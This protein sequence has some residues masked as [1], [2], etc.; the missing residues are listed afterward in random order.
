MDSTSFLF[1]FD[2]SEL[3]FR[4]IFWISARK[5]EFL[6]FLKTKIFSHPCSQNYSIYTAWAEKP[7]ENQNASHLIR[8]ILYFLR[9]FFTGSRPDF[10]ISKNIC[11]IFWMNRQKI[12][13]RNKITVVFVYKWT[14]SI[15]QNKPPIREKQFLKIHS[16][17]T[18]QKK[19]VRTHS[20]LQ[21]I[22]ELQTTIRNPW[23][24]VRSGPIGPEVDILI[25]DP[26]TIRDVTLSGRKFLL[27][28]SIDYSIPWFVQ[29]KK[30]CSGKFWSRSVP[31]WVSENIWS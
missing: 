12:S 27:V 13:L 5:L 16:S 28:Q 4:R 18:E 10:D 25:F 11:F 26:G 2:Y 17:L 6:D 30:F 31:V 9:Q 21:S 29:F 8:F 23:T 1:N 19:W 20:T 7:V 14:F 3:Y 15:C 24:A 22:V